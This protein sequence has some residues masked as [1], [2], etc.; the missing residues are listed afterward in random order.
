MRAAF[1][2]KILKRSRRF[3]RQSLHKQAPKS[4]SFRH[5]FPKESKNKSF[6]FF[7]QK[8]FLFKITCVRIGTAQLRIKMI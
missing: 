6:L 3:Q 5:T 1:L 4:G 8:G 7:P 2:L